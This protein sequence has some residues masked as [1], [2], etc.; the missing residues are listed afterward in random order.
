M[1]WERDLF[2]GDEGFDRYGV[3]W[4]VAVEVVCDRTYEV[5]R[6]LVAI[7]LAGGGNHQTLIKAALIALPLPNCENSESFSIS[8]RS[9]HSLTCADAGAP[10]T[11]IT[12]F[13]WMANRC[14][15]GKSPP[16]KASEKTRSGDRCWKAS[17]RFGDRYSEEY[18]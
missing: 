8:I 7:D 14:Y 15:S 1:G 6:S 16:I 5:C 11:E 9:M 13:R 10:D 17:P 4:S 18:S 12:L 2:V 3:Y